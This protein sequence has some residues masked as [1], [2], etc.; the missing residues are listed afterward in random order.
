VVGCPWFV[1]GGRP[2][3][4]VFCFDYHKNGESAINEMPECG[5]GF[6]EDPAAQPP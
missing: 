6:A 2:L 4:P 5:T 1:A 3:S